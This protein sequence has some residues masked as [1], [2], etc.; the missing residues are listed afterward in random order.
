MEANLQSF[1]DLEKNL[2]DENINPAEM[3][4]VIQWNKRDL[5]DVISAEELDKSINKFGCPTVEASAVTGEGVFLT[6]RKAAELILLKLNTDWGCKDGVHK[7]WV[8]VDVDSKEDALHAL[9][10]PY[11][12]AAT[13]VKLNQFTMEDMDELMEH[14]AK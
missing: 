11:R 10:P 13:I 14:H 2:R 7:A 12:G 1:A 4:L 8:V 3:P 9:P 5:P 6:L